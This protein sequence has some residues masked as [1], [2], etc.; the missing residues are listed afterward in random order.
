VA[1][2]EVPSQAKSPLL[3]VTSSSVS[4]QSGS[5]TSDLVI[6]NQQVQED[7]EGVSCVVLEGKKP[8][9]ME[10]VL[11]RSKVSEEEVVVVPKTSLLEH[12][13]DQSAV[14][15]GMSSSEP[16]SAGAELEEDIPPVA[17]SSAGLASTKD[18]LSE[19]EVE[20]HSL[21][22]EPPRSEDSGREEDE[23]TLDEGLS[24]NQDVQQRHSYLSALRNQE[25]F[26]ETLSSISEEMLDEDENISEVDAGSGSSKLNDGQ[27]VPSEKPCEEDTTGSSDKEKATVTSTESEDSLDERRSQGQGGEAEA[28]SNGS[29]LEKDLG[30]HDRQRGLDKEEVD[31]GV[32]EAAASAEDVTDGDLK[33]KRSA[34]AKEDSR[35][36]TSKPK[37][38]LFFMRDKKSQTEL[39]EVR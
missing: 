3:Q 32:S 17:T 39:T 1:S 24:S 25:D 7:I 5:Q 23:H 8:G 14:E 35:S 12:N 26:G 29:E 9:K 38:L 28:V 4:S 13:E 10:D 31:A 36:A 21:P 37:D 34:I 11:K 16:A 6:S 20:E 19:A 2:G 27:N 30:G 18:G 33:E 15:D 22:S